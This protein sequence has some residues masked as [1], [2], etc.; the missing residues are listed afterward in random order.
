VTIASVLLVLIAALVWWGIARV[1]QA[2]SAVQSVVAAAHFQIVAMRRRLLWA[3][4]F[5][6]LHQAQIAY[7]LVVR[8]SSG[9]NAVMWAVWGRTW[10]FGRDELEL[11]WESGERLDTAGGGRG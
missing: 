9:T 7:R 10:F 4:P 5:G 11:R 8:D 2:R 6:L 3:G 1:R